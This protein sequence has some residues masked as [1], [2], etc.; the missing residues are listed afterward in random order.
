MVSFR[1]GEDIS[2]SR[3]KVTATELKN[4]L[5][6]YLEAAIAAP[7]FVEKSGREVAVLMSHEHYTYLQALEDRWWGEQ[8]K[9]AEQRGF[10]GVEETARALAAL[11]PPEDEDMC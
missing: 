11:Q 2:M 3:R 5:G 10:L 4:H 7:V 1:T 8:A 9:L 6:A